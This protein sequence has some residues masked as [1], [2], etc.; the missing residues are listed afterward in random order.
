MVGRDESL[1]AASSSGLRKSAF[2][3]VRIWNSLEQSKQCPPNTHG[4]D[5]NQVAA[6]VLATG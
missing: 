2:L 5:G 1:A 6:K 4:K 3:L